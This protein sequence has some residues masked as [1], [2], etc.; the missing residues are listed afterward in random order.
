MSEAFF[1]YARERHLVYLRRRA[2]LP[3]DQWT[4]D[5]VLRQFRFCNVFRELDTTTIWF[6]EHVRDPLR[7]TPNVLLATVLFR[8]FNRIATG[9]A[10]FSQTMLDPDFGSITAWHCLLESGRSDSLISSVLSYC[11]RGPYVTGSY[12]IKTP[13]GKNK[14]DGVLWCVEQFMTQHQTW[15]PDGPLSQQKMAK[16][17]LDE[18]GEISLESVWRWLRQFPYMGDFMAYEVVTDLR[19]TA[20]LDQ[21]PDIM[22]WANPGPGAMRGLNRIHGR[23]LASKVSK[24]QACLEMRQL[25][26]ESCDSDRWPQQSADGKLTVDASISQH[27]AEDSYLFR[28]EDWPRWEMRDVEHTLCEWD[29]HQRVTLGQG[30]TKQ[31]FRG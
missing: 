4:A 20:L 8:W 30:K 19:H 18:P 10:I 11:G 9:E 16:L 24:Q 3:R 27:V 1:D 15:D 12:I 31:I 29:K 2:G 23:P 13:D 28:H 6:R 22:T 14:L 17:L 7:H 5:P 21:A 26:E 25:L